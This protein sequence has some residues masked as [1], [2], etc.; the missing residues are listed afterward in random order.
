MTVNEPYAL[1]P[2]DHNASDSGGVSG[3]SGVSRQ[4]APRDDGGDEGDNDLAGNEPPLTGAVEGISGLGAMVLPDDIVILSSV[5][6]VQGLNGMAGLSANGAIR[7]VTDWL[8]EVDANEWAQPAGQAG[9]QPDHFDYTG[10]N[11]SMTLGLSGAGELSMRTL[12]VGDGL[13]VID[14]GARGVAD[15]NGL[16]DGLRVLS[17]DGRPLPWHI[18]RANGRTILVDIPAGRDWISL[19]LERTGADGAVERWDV[20]INLQSGEI[21]QTGYEGRQASAAPFL[22]Q[23]ERL[24]AQADNDASALM[25]ALAG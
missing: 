1:T 6:D 20:R 25:R 10:Q 14:L 2:E 4:A 3:A 24:A 18:T 15:A 13:M 8:R 21:I 23:V 19:R 5:N 17:A 12:V 7:Q 16:L 11:L 22:D 9:E